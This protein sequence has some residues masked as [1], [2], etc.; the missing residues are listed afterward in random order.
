[1]ISRSSRSVLVR[2][3]I[4]EPRRRFCSTQIGHTGSGRLP[5]HFSLSRFQRIAGLRSNQPEE[6]AGLSRH[7]RIA[8]KPRY[9]TFGGGARTAC[10][11]ERGSP[12]LMVAHVD[13]VCTPYWAAE[14]AGGRLFHNALD[15]R[16][17]VYLGLEVL[18][19]MGVRTDLLLTTGEEEG[20]STAALFRTR[21]RYN[22]MFSFDRQGEDVV[23]YQYACAAL[24]GIFQE[25]GF[26]VGDGTYS[27]IAELEHLGCCGMNFG[28]GMFDCHDEG[29]FCDLAMLGRQLTRFASFYRKYSRVLLPHKPSVG[30]RLGSAAH[31]REG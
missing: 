17:G 16:L 21:K 28:C 30:T 14:I 3:L 27:C 18:P 10:L 25:A 24:A 13:T 20:R 8:G 23:C 31:Y 29:A 22:W 19:A 7:G 4:G 9:K 12:T 11:I 6:F 1:M 5:E 15:D 2:T 26:T